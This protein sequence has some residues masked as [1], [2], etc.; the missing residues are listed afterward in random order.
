MNLQDILNIVLILGLL[1]LSACVVFVTYFF[2]QA[3]RSITD[4]SDELSEVAQNVKDK[5]GLKVL[6]AVPKLFMSIISNLIK[7]R[8]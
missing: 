5:V 3:L 6:Q 4:L 1:I 7:K 8:G 2:I